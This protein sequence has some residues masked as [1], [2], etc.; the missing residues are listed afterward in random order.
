M[1]EEIEVDPVVLHPRSAAAQ[2][3]TIESQRR[4]D[5]VDGYGQMQ[6]GEAHGLVSVCFTGRV[7]WVRDLMASN[8]GAR[9]R[10]MADGISSCSC[11]LCHFRV[12]VRARLRGTA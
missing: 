2:Q 1:A 11:F 8:L 10:A 6:H 5:V 3:V 12:V 4:V 9:L 7:Y